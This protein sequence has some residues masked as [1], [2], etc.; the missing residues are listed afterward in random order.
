MV[1][2]NLVSLISFFS[3]TNKSNKLVNSLLDKFISL[4]EIKRRVGRAS[5]I[6]L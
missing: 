3:D 4:F 2:V 5:S 1:Y 6:N